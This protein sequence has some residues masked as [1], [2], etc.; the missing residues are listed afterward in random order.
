MLPVD[1]DYFRQLRHYLA[2]IAAG[3]D[4]YFPPFGAS[5]AEGI[6]APGVDPAT[7]ALYSPD[8]QPPGPALD[9]E[10]PDPTRMKHRFPR[11]HHALTSVTLAR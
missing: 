6:A 4:L 3:T 8:S 7:L 2:S 10:P 9:V 1:R 5:I 11:K